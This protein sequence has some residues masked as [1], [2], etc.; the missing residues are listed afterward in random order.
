MSNLFA[1]TMM[2]LVCS[3]PLARAGNGTRPLATA[4][5]QD[6]TCYARDLA[7]ALTGTPQAVVMKRVIDFQ[8]GRLRVYSQSREKI[9]RIAETWKKRSDWSVITVYGYGGA[10]KGVHSGPGTLGQKRADKIRGYFIRYGVPAEDVVAVG[11]AD[12]PGRAA[13]V[14]LSID[15]CTRESPCARSAVVAAP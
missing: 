2:A 3:V 6:P 1:M 14:G 12:E 5:D 15:V 8:P 4:C 13:T 9:Q 7:L 10:S 11:H